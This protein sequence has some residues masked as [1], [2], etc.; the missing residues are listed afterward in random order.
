MTPVP[1]NH[2]HSRAPQKIGGKM[3]RTAKH[4]PV[5]PSVRV[6]C[7]RGCGSLSI[8]TGVRTLAIAAL[9]PGARQ[10]S[11]HPPR[12]CATVSEAAIVTQVVSTATTPAR[13]LILP[14]RPAP[15]A[16][17]RWYVYARAVVCRWLVLY[18]PLVPAAHGLCMIPTAAH[19]HARA[20]CSRVRLHA[21]DC[22][23]CTALLACDP[24]RLSRVP[25]PLCY[26]RC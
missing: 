11:T 6:L 1:I 15:L 26:G 20:S 25:C 9:L 16:S 21:L 7:E 17:T 8:G 4:Q 3:G 14:C 13:L 12:A 18:H 10:C 2:H 23:C 19:M 24:L 5:L 22:L